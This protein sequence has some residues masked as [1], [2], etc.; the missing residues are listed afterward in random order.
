MQSGAVISDTQVRLTN[1]ETRDTRL[2]MLLTY[3]SGS[4][5]CVLPLQFTYRPLLFHVNRRYH[6]NGYWRVADERI[7]KE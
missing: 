3:S 1:I 7:G 2:T 6:P 4:R 5:H